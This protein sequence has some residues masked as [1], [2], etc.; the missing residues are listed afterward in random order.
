[1]EEVQARTEAAEEWRR[2]DS[3]REPGEARIELEIKGF[4]DFNGDGIED[5][6]LFKS[7]TVIEGT[8]YAYYPVILTRLAAG[9]PV[10]AFEVK[11]DDIEKAARSCCTLDLISSQRTAAKRE[12][13]L[14]RRS[15][16]SLNA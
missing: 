1:V 14:D 6:L 2:L 9:G 8:F 5:I 7:D 4:G 10:K 11:D 3:G 12:I 15:T 16:S 13:A